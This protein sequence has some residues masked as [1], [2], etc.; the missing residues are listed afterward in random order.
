M[1]AQGIPGSVQGAGAGAVKPLFEPEDPRPRQWWWSRSR[2][3]SHLTVVLRMPVP[4]TA[5]RLIQQ[6]AFL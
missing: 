1:H 6:A 4:R 3:K 5:D 2:A